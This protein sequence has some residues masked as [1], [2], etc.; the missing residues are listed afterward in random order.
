MAYGASPP[1]H[2]A[3]PSEH[4]EAAEAA[5]AKSAGQEMLVLVDGIGEAMVKDAIPRLLGKIT[6]AE[7]RESFMRQLAASRFAVSIH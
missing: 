6:H 5:I 1:Y 2:I 4:E 3:I 7:E